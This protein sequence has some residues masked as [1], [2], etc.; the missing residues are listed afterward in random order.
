MTLHS[1][2]TTEPAITETDPRP[3][4]QIAGDAWA[5]AALDWA[6]GFEP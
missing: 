4:W 3:D 2:S 6:Y 1:E 5:H